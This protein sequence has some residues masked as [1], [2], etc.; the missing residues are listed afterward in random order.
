MGWG[1]KGRGSE[2]ELRFHSGSAHPAQEPDCCNLTLQVN[3]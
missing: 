1:E 2:L 3:N